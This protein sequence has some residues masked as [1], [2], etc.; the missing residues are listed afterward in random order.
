MGTFKYFDDSMQTQELNVRQK[1]PN[2]LS[3]FRSEI[4]TNGFYQEIEQINGTS[5]KDLKNVDSG[6]TIFILN[7]M[8]IRIL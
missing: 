6:Q 2:D 8:V 1:S 5:F 3:F 4:L 7:L